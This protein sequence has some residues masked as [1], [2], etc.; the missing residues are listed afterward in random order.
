MRIKNTKANFNYN[1]EQKFEAGIALLGSEV[2]SIK[3]NTASVNLSS[4]HIIIEETSAFIVN[5]NIPEYKNKVKDESI[6]NPTRKRRLLLHKQQID[7][8]RGAVNV[9]KYTAIVTECYI[10]D[11]GKIK[12]EIAIAKGKKE[13]DKRE[14]LKEKDCRRENKR[15]QDSP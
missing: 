2:K 9:D 8:I 5:L 15:F 10:N 4:A 7:K 14:Y 3:S 6:Y 12:L 1:I 13:H 11:K